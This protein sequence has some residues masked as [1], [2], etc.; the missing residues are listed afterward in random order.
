MKKI[1]IGLLSLIIVILSGTFVYHSHESWKP[2]RCNSHLNSHITS[3][4]GNTLELNLEIDIVAAHEGSSEFFVVGSLKDSGNSYVISRR[5][6]T[7]INRYS[8]KDYAKAL[9]TRE[10]LDPIDDTPDDLWNKYVIP[11]TQGIHFYM[12]MKRINNKIYLIKGVS[13]PFFVCVTT[14]D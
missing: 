8:F 3:R 4:D 11:A 7:T 14:Q 2:F 1:V 10:E 5:I 13:N 6:I 9:I 12:E